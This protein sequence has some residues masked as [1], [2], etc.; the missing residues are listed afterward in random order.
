MISEES[1]NEKDGHEDIHGNRVL[2]EVGYYSAHVMASKFEH[3]F[4]GKRLEQGLLESKPL[5][6]V[7]E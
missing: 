4:Q 7:R 6:Q 3:P 5:I 2:N 1:K